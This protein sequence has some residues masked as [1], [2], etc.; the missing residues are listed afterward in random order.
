MR[1]GREGHALMEL[2]IAIPIL[3]IAGAAV[4]GFILLSSALLLESERRLETA[5]PGLALLDSLAAT[6]PGDTLSGVFEAG[7]REVPWN[8]D[9]SGGL[10]LHLPEPASEPW[11]LRRSR[12]VEP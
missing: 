4:T 1:R 3:G 12:P 11:R 5:G 9:G 10:E 7:G 6:T 2:V 8:W